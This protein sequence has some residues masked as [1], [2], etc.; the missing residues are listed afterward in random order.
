MR[1]SDDVAGATPGAQ[2]AGRAPESHADGDADAG[3]EE[4]NDPETS[5]LP[6]GLTRELSCGGPPSETNAPARKQIGGPPEAPAF[7]LVR[8]SGCQG[9][10]SDVESEGRRPHQAVIA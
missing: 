9:G 6:G 4:S 3:H 7:G 8:G 5:L 1:P 10:G 2:E